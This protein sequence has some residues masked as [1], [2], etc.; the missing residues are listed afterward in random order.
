VFKPST[1]E[2]YLRA[3]LTT[4]VEDIGKEVVNVPRICE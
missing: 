2:K 4:T 3:D 1:I